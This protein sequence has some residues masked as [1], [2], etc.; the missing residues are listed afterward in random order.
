M[1]HTVYNQI[2]SDYVHTYRSRT[3]A[4]KNTELRALYN[5]IIRINKQSP[6][7]MF[8][9]NS[10]VPSYAI[11]LKDSAIALSTDL[12]QYLLASGKRLFDARKATSENEAS[13]SVEL[14]SGKE[15]ELPEEFTVRVENLATSQVNTGK[16]VYSESSGLRPGMYSFQINIENNLYEFQFNVAERSTNKENLTKLARFINQSSIG[17]TASVEEHSQEETCQIQ[18]RSN[19][20]GTLG[21]NTFTF[22]DKEKGPD[23]NGIIEFFDF[24]RVTQYPKNSNFEIN[25]ISKESLSNSFTYNKSLKITLN[26]PS[27]EPV[28]IRYTPDTDS[29]LK[30]LDAT[31]KTYN[32]FM[33]VLKENGS[34]QKTSISLAN[35][36]KN[37]FRAYKN[38]LE[39]CG[40]QMKEDGSLTVDKAL[41]TFS[42]QDGTIEDMLTS[43]DGIVGNLIG[44]M[45]QI[46][47]D[48]MNYVDKTIVTYPNTE[49]TIYPN[50]Y[51]SSL[52]SGM[53]CNYY[54]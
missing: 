14:L 20:T 4:V 42:A 10:D 30:R 47:L 31:V 29:I 23:G 44:K 32:Q 34:T 54:C 36:M 22:F 8:K 21:T 48:P 46:M 43:R 33:T 53:I 24:N 2:V 27:E 6:V 9:M 17:V 26:S 49:K 38:E 37:L 3:N 45:N 5:S 18:I 52:Y 39:P 15:D 7:Y 19:T 28:A 1:I 41:S 25:G 51:V 40:L 35:E 16:S 13:V 11:A 50:P 12:G